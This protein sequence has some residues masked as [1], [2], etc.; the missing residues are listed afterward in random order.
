MR[1][2]VQDQLGQHGET[3]STKN[4]KFSQ[5]WWRI[6]IIPATWEAEAGESLISGRRR[7]QG[8][9]TVPPYSSLGDR[10]RLHPKKKK[11]K[12]ESLRLKCFTW[13]EWGGSCLYSQHFGR[14]RKA[15][16]LRPEV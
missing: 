16:H 13:A 9:E 1:S 8:A 6:P 3:V 7:L 2:G 12:D 10:E 14:L 15:H 11:C 5:A 4:A